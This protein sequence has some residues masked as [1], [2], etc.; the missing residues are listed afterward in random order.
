MRLV[1]QRVSEARVK[2]DGEISGEI[3]TGILIFVGF[4][5][6]DTHE[7]IIKVTDR[8]IWL[9]I[10]SDKDGRMGLSVMET[11]DD[12]LVVSQFSLHASFKKGN[13]PS[14]TKALKY[15]DAILLY[16]AFIE[17]LE[18]ESKK[19]IA[20]GVFGADMQV[21]LINDGPVT[22]ILDSRN[23]EL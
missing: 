1:V 7:D 4:D 15:D 16:N 20:T 12:I 9:K 6:D 5:Q 3:G 21:E 8:V 23:K 2:V 19:P 17:R 11:K 13:K 10:M 18:N 14:F 22:M